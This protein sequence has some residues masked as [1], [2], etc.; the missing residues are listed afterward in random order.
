LLAV[1]TARRLAPFVGQRSA[2]LARKR[3]AIQGRRQKIAV[4]CEAQLETAADVRGGDDRTSGYS[5]ATGGI[6]SIEFSA[7]HCLP[8]RQF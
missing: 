7:G 4:A 1:D 8:D 6:V 3:V 5:S 2:R